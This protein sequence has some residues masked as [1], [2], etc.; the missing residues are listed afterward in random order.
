MNTVR[1]VADLRSA[2]SDARRPVG[3]VPT[4]G[5]LHAGHVALLRRARTECETVV[6]SLFINPAQFNASEDLDSYPRDESADSA[7]AEREGVDL[8]FAPGLAEVYPAGFQTSVEVAD[9]GAVLEGDE[10]ARG[11]EHLRGV[12]TVV[13]KLLNMAS[14]DIAYFGQKDA[15]QLAVIRRLVT[16]LDLGV[17]IEA[18]ATVREPDGLA[19]SSRNALLSAAD[20]ERAAAL[21]RALRAGA[22][23]VARGE[24]DAAAVLDAASRVLQAGG[25]EP[26]YLALVSPSDLSPVARVNGSTLLAVAARVGRTRLIDNALVGGESLAPVPGAEE[27]LT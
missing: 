12:A 4:M 13:A 8:V 23:V 21:S 5:A 19:L 24:R 7:I 11:P 9:L 15:Q 3:L 27:A 17:R 6:M 18:V 25:I 1:T 16:D 14:P 10:S 20:R 2:L 22:A 26:D